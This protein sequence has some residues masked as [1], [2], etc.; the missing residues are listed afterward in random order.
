MLVNKDAC[1]KSTEGEIYMDGNDI[2]LTIQEGMKKNPEAMRAILQ[3]IQLGY[4]LA[5]MDQCKA[6]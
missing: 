2:I 6:G 3:A 1:S 5:E 4:T